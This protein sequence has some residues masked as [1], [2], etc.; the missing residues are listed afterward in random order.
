MRYLNHKLVGLA[1]MGAAV[2][3]CTDEYDCNLQV[4]KPE[5][6]ANSEY[7]ASFDV[8]KSYISRGGADDPFRLMVNMTSTDFMKKDIAYSTVLNNFDGIDIGSSFTPINSLKDDGSYDF[9]NMQLL[10]DAVAETDLTLYGGALCSNQGQRAAYYNGLIQPVIIPFVPEKGK[11]V[12]FNFEDDA[13]GTAYGMTGGSQA[14]VEEDP[15]GRSGKVLHVGTEAD[16]A[17]YSHPKFNVKLP[18]GRKLGDYINLTIDMRIVNNDGLWGAGMRVFING[19]E[20]AIGTNAQGF[21]CNSNTWN[22]GA[23]ISLTSDTAPGFILPESLKELTEFELAVGSASGGAQFYLDNIVMNY[24]VAAKGVTKIDFEQDAIGTSY[25]MTN[26]NQAVVEEDPEGQSGKVLH[27]GTSGSLCSYTYPKFNVQLQSGRTLGDYTALSLDMYL[28]DGKG[29][30]GS[31]I[32]VIINGQ[33]FNCGQGP[34]G[35]G[36][37]SNK[38]GR[39][40]I[41]ITFLQEGETAEAG[42]IVIPNSMRDLTEIELAVGSGSGEWHAYIDNINLHW[43]ADDTIIEKTP[44][45]KKTLFTE[46]LNKW[47]GGMVNAGGEVARAWNIVSEPL[48]RTV[49]GNTFDWSEYLGSEEYARTAVQLA[50]DTAKV[51][52]T[53]Y[54]SNTFNQYDELG[55]KADQLIALVNAWEADGKT[56]IDG[57]NILL[58]AVYSEDALFQQGNE[59]AISELFTKLAQTGKSVRVSDLSVRVENAE[60]NF[61]QTGNLTSVQRS[62]AANY[63]AFI[64]KEYR[65]RI[66]ANKQTGISLSGLTESSSDSRLCPWTSGYNRNGMYEGVV[67][68]LKQLTIDN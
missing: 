63:L 35:F 33:E 58:H 3:A 64:M 5:E 59:A 13:L 67:E 4:E 37:E 25:P 17:A 21:G 32:R 39:E 24:E 22:R 44:E 46:E 62:A 12:L 55:Q 61:I 54:V 34:F 42:K 27:V 14:V 57:Y 18:E 65:K 68:G 8:L 38:W 20:F 36:C 50:R 43:K 30:W 15:E 40:K 16:K 66:A 51:D 2:V 9:G 19:Q 1:L 56:R 7:L 41:Y 60:G 49:D 26:G 10:A 23:V 28:I 45:E 31:G 53:L 52:L 11:T 29:G 48:D 6:V 47:I